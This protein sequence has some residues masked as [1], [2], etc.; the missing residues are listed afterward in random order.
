LLGNNASR[1]FIGFGHAGSTAGVQYFTSAS[2]GA[3]SWFNTAPAI[4]PGEGFLLSVVQQGGPV[5]GISYA[6]AAKNGSA[7]YGQSVFVPPVIARSQNYV[8][9]SYWSDGKFQG[10]I[11]EILIYNRTLSAAEQSAMRAYISQKYG[12]TVQ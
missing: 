6:E 11:A 4:S 12:I 10:D 5:G 8:G 2:A 3:V 7:L 9:N 1:D